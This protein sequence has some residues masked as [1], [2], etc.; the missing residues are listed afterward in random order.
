MSGTIGPIAVSLVGAGGAI[1]GGTIASASNMLVE[2]Q[3]HKRANS[4]Q[5]VNESQDRRVAARL[6]RGELVTCCSVLRTAKGDADWKASPQKVLPVACWEQ[7]GPVLARQLSY[8]DWNLTRNAYQM[9][10]VMRLATARQMADAALA[11]LAI[12]A[13]EKVEPCLRAASQ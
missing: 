12:E 10:Q 5:E 7:Y 11:Q 3:R 8:Q 9:V 1:I 2:S 6:V 13:I 4:R